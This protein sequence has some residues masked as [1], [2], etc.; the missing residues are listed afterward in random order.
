MINYVKWGWVLGGVIA[1]SVLDLVYM[2]WTRSAPG[3]SF[4]RAGWQASALGRGH[5]DVMKLGKV[6]HR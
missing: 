1:A 3:H 6:F 2:F 4:H 5:Y